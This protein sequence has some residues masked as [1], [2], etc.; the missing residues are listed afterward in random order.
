MREC[1]S[2]GASSHERLVLQYSVKVAD[3]VALEESGR[4]AAALAFR[5][6]S[7]DVRLCPGVVLTALEDD[8]VLGAVK[9]AAALNAIKSVKTNAADATTEDQAEGESSSR[10]AHELPQH[11]RGRFVKR[12]A[13]RLVAEGRAGIRE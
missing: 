7:F 9:Q 6:A 8:R 1:C 10:I 2:Y 3:E 11:L 13:E 5:D 4:F 12:S